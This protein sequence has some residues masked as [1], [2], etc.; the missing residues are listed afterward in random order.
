VTNRFSEELSREVEVLR[1]KVQTLSIAQRR[2]ERAVVKL[3]EAVEL[4]EAIG[5]SRSSDAN[6]HKL[7]SA[8]SPELAK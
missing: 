8:G 6:L 1:G 7:T 4:V 3:V 2:I 5:D